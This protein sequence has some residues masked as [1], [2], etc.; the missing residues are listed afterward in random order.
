MMFDKSRGGELTSK[1]G[2][3]DK[4]LVLLIDIIE[5]IYLHSFSK[6]PTCARSCEKVH[7]KE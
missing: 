5:L 7:I 6:I 2:L 1:V 3:C 4:S